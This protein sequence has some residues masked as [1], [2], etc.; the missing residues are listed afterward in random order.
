MER[1]EALAELT[2]RY[3]RSHAPAT[4]RDYVWWSGLRT[5]DA[6]RGLEIVRAR[7]AEVDGLKYWSLGRT[8]RAG[9]RSKTGVHLLPVYDEYL[10][11]YRDLQAVPRPAYLLGSFQHALVIEGQVGGSWR[12]SAGPEGVKVN[13]TPHRTLAA[14]ERRAL[15][16]AVTRYGQFLKVRAAFLST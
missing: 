6:K 11:A 2:R 1:E 14:G 13:V 9:S 12:T 7:S 10:V 16:R 4:V 3:L 5:S 8:P 15:A